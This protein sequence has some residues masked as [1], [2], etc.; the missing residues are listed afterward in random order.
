MREP[1]TLQG[2]RRKNDVVSIVLIAPSVC[3]LHCFTGTPYADL[4][5]I[6]AQQGQAASLPL[7]SLFLLN[8]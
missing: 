7:V 5:D 1:A 6:A 3:E 2:N 8:W 4:T